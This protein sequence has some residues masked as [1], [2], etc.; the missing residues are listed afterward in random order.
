MTKKVRRNQRGSGII[1]G[2]CVLALIIT[3]GVGTT[4]LVLNT[5][6]SIFFRNKLSLVTTEAAQYA[7]NHQSD[8]SV[9]EETRSY[10]KG[11]MKSIGLDTDLVTVK[12]AQTTNGVA[13][14]NV[15]VAK[16]FP[17]FGTL[18]FHLPTQIT[19]E[20]TEFGNGT[21]TNGT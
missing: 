5:G 8:S 17:L 9:E 14:V 16:T 6:T 10:A 7:V 3:I 21:G 20:D 12:V 13:G 1:E 11:I 4:L 18:G 19:I 15:T 2:T